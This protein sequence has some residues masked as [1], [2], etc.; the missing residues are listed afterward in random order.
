MTGSSQAVK[1]VP[2]APLF[3]L[4]N[5]FV[6][7]LRDRELPRSEPDDLRRLR[8]A[9][10][11]Y[12]F[13]LSDDLNLSSNHRAI[14]SASRTFLLCEI[15]STGSNEPTEMATQRSCRHAADRPNV[16]RQIP[17]VLQPSDT[18][19]VTPTSYSASTVASSRRRSISGVTAVVSRLTKVARTTSLPDPSAAE[20]L[21]A[22]PQRSF[23]LPRSS[24]S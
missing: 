3:T 6:E 20:R 19:S 4:C 14:S 8:E 2:E 11:S 1:D 16:P 13:N 22:E 21:F 23:G 12:G 24:S 9:F 10:A 17:L 18:R 7:L 5:Q 15:T